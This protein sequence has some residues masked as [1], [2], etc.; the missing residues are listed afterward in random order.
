MSK[1]IVTSPL[2]YEWIC[3]RKLLLLICIHIITPTL[4]EITFERNTQGHM[5]IFFSFNLFRDFFPPSI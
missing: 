1:H 5:L 2:N 4:T 3:I